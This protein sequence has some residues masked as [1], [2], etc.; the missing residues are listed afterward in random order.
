MKRGFIRL[1][2]W[3]RTG[4][5]QQG[6]FPPSR[7]FRCVTTLAIYSAPALTRVMEPLFPRKV[8]PL[9]SLASA[10]LSMRARVDQL[11]SGATFQK[12]VI[13]V[14]VANAIVLGLETSQSMMALAGPLLVALDKA[15]L[16]FF[17]I[18]LLL[19]LYAKRIS[20]F[21]DGW[22]LFDLAIVVISLVPASQGASVIRA[23]RILRVLRLISAVP[24][25]RAV[26]AALVSAIPP[27][28]SVIAILMLIFYVFAVMATK[29]FGTAFPDWFGS[30]G[31]S[32]YS[33]FQVMTLESWSMGIVRPVMDV[34]PAAWAFFVPFIMLTTFAVMNL[35]VAIVVNSMQSAHE[36]DVQAANAERQDQLE[37][38]AAEVRALRELVR[39]RLDERQG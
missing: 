35:F 27:M 16:A 21:R 6:H 7:L 24:K 1:L 20:F 29:L 13:G 36:A 2:I 25:M 17:V 8:F 14:I 37:V 4:G 33:L 18:E 5:D 9:M 22:N 38:L 30:I 3:R 39:E 15:A 12:V 34:Y 19:K 32:L 26:V 28:G 10:P 23:L 11:V 31:A